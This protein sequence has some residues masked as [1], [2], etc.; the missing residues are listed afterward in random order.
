MTAPTWASLSQKQRLAVLAAAGSIDSFELDGEMVSIDD[1]IG[2]AEALVISGTEDELHEICATP[3][4][5]VMSSRAGRAVA[6][7]C[8]CAPGHTPESAECLAC[9]ARACPHH[10]PLHYHHDGC[11][12]CDVVAS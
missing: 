10:E 9:G 7:V 12:A 1:I 2:T 6:L 4:D 5:L 11:P 8:M 3:L